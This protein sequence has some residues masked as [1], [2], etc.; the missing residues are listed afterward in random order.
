M[1]VLKKIPNPV[2]LSWKICYLS[3]YC[4]SHPNLP[5]IA[6]SVITKVDP[7]TIS[8]LSAGSMSGLSVE[9]SG[10]TLEKEGVSHSSSG[11]HSL[12]VPTVYNPC[13]TKGLACL[14]H[15]PWQLFKLFFNEFWWKH[16][17]RTVPLVPRGWIL[18]KFP[19]CNISEN[20]SSTRKAQLFLLQ[21]GLILAL[22]L[23]KVMLI[24]QVRAKKFCFI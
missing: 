21:P 10:R 3:M 6:C 24:G 18:S 17:P 14:R 23:N 12:Q 11:I 5:F 7:A 8:L 9:G 16:V 1:I 15:F 2:A 13:S 22:G 4:F 19:G 20:C